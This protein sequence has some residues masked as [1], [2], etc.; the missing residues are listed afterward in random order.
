ME[1]IQG[2]TLQAPALPSTAPS[3][4]APLFPASTKYKEI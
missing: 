2:K 4:H 1:K 3:K